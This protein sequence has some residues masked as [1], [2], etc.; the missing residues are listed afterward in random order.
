MRSL[1]FR[2]VIAAVIAGS[3]GGLAGAAPVSDKQLKPVERTVVVYLPPMVRH[4]RLYLGPPQDTW[5]TPGQA[6]E[7]ATVDS[8]RA[9]FRTVFLR[10]G[11][12]AST[13]QLLL[14]VHP[15]WNFKDRQHAE[16]T[17][18]YKLLDAKGTVVTEG[19]KA[20]DADPVRLF[21]DNDF[22]TETL[23]ASAQVAADAAVAV[24]ALGAQGATDTTV[25]GDIP[26]VELVSRD[27]PVQSGTGF[28]I[29]TKGQ[30][31]TAAHVVHECLVTQVKRD[32]VA[33][34]ATVVAQSA[35]LDLAVLDTGKPVTTVLPLRTDTDF[36]L[37]E[38]VTNV[39]YPL[40]GVLAGSPNLT[41]GNI[42]SRTA[43]TG[44]LGLFQ[45]SAPIQPGSS[46]GPVVSDG[47]ELLGITVGT[48]NLQA[49]VRQGVLPQN[50][51]FALDA[52]YAAQFMTRNHVEFRSVKPSTKGDAQTANAAALSTVV[53]L[54]CFQ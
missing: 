35:L 48:L 54:G 4:F 7:D 40:E 51:N 38:G 3:V 41:R 15:K 44:S 43:M 46:G 45:F 19:V 10:D 9:H 1:V 18:N 13:Y 11:Q 31:L 26:P 23:R 50:V 37:G 33:L 6:L 17:M 29:N 8:M 49:L 53:Q 14:V 34:D 27:K 32:D 20:I 39:G 22:Y 30:I 2:F 47:G 28:Y 36:T 52:K 25:V 16:L 21:R 12:P 42:S 24:T 5:L